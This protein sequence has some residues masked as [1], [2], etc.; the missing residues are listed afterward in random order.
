MKYLLPILIGI[1]VMFGKEAFSYQNPNPTTQSLTE[2]A[3]EV[4]VIEVESL[5]IDGDLVK[6]Q[7]GD[8]TYTEEAK[9]LQKVG[10]LLISS[11]GK[12]YQLSIDDTAYLLEMMCS[13]PAK[14]LVGLVLDFL[15][16]PPSISHDPNTPDLE[17][18]PYKHREDEWNERIRRQKEQEEETRE[19]HKSFHDDG[20][21]IVTDDPRGGMIV[22]EPRYSYDRVPN[23]TL[24]MQSRGNSITHEM[25]DGMIHENSTDN[26]IDPNKGH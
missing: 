2:D 8:T 16:C 15:L 13:T 25:V 26:L 24:P 3:D 1:L 11:S 20:D 18:D 4:T 19:L 17:F 6:L 7:S 21:V 9:D 22:V 12:V 23:D 10:D 5:E 14:R